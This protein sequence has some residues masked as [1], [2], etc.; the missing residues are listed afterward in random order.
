MSPRAWFDSRRSDPFD[1]SRRDGLVALGCLISSTRGVRFSGGAPTCHCGGTGQTHQAENLGLHCGAWGF[2]PPRWHREPMRSL[3]RDCGGTW[4][5]APVSDAGVREDI[6]V[7]I[8][9]VAP[10]GWWKDWKTLPPQN[11]PPPRGLEGSSPSPSTRRQFGPMTRAPRCAPNHE[12]G[13]GSA[14]SIANPGKE[15]VQPL[16]QRCPCGSKRR[17]LVGAL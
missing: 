15:L 6:R 9:A 3:S 5:D 2:E 13:H 12:L 1:C 11:R 7:R 17:R 10:L 16:R 14:I 8:P 4:A